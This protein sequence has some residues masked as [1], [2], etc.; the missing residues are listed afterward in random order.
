MFKDLSARVNL[1]E[2]AASR[3][4]KEQDDLLQKDAAASERA[5]EVL[6][7]LEMERDLKWKA[8]DRSTALQQRVDQDAE[9]IARLHGEREELRR[10]EERL[11]SERGMAREERDQAVREHDKAQQRVGSLEAKLRTMT[12]RR[13][14]AESVSTGLA[15]ELAEARRNL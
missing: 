11:R 5:V 10:T 15:T 1:D 2:E 7:E 14:E 9:V 12:T 13:L 6:A 3:I 4:Q 8:E